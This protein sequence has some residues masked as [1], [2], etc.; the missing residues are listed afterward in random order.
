MFKKSRNYL[1]LTL[2]VL[3]AILSS[4][5]IEGKKVFLTFGIVI[6]LFALYRISMN[7]PSK[8]S[9]DNDLEN[10]GGDEV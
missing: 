1:L 9:D 8:K 6:M 7:I 2:G 10:Y 5:V 3:I 4:Y